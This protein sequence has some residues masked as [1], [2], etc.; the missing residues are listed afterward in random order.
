MFADVYNSYLLLFFMIYVNSTNFITVSNEE[1]LERYARIFT[2]RV[3]M[4][5]LQLATKDIK[6]LF[7]LSLLYII[8]FF[9][10]Y[11]K[12]LV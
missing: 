10:K 8:I 3:A 2:F 4:Q 12:K 9:V 11:V 7:S 6:K 5:Q 1:I